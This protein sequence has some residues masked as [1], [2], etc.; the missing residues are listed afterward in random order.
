MS[1]HRRFLPD[2]ETLKKIRQNCLNDED[3]IKRIRGK[4]DALEGSTESFEYLREIE[5][6]IKDGINRSDEE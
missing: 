6:K 2:V 4:A 1:F 5:E 3:F